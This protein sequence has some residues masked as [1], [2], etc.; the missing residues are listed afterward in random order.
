MHISVKSKKQNSKM[1][2]LMNEKKKIMKKT[3]LKVED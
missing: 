3:K 1:D 2:E